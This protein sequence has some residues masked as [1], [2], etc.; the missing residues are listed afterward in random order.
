MCIR[1]SVITF[2]IFRGLNTIIKGWTL[3]AR[4]GV[5]FTSFLVVSIGAHML[6]HKGKL[7]KGAEWGWLL[8]ET[9]LMFALLEAGGYFGRDAFMKMQIAGRNIRAGNLATRLDGIRADAD[10]LRLDYNA[11]FDSSTRAEKIALADR[12]AKTLEQHEALLTELASL[13]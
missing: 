12:Y 13:K 11:A 6:S 2:G 4:L 7:P 5:T 8:Y 3:A 9:V 1:D 10:K